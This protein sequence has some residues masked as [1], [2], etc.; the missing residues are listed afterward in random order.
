GEQEITKRS[1]NTV[2]ELLRQVPGVSPG[3]GTQV[4][5]GSNG[6][7][8]IDLRGLGVQRNLVLLDGNRLVPSRAD[9]AVDLNAMPLALI[10]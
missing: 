7:N 10:S 6:L 3:I 9:G 2:E 1:P 8:T 4:N 5:N